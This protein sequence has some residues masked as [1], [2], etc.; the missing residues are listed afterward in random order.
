[1]SCYPISLLSSSGQPEGGRLARTE[2]S[3]AE[4]LV[5]YNALRLKKSASGAV[6]QQF[7]CR[8][9]HVSENADKAIDAL[10]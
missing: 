9:F 7:D 6:S 10:L 4:L 5:F 3:L 8:L 2:Y 1:M